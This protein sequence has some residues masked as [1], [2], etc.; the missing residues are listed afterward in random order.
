MGVGYHEFYALVLPSVKDG[1]GGVDD[2]AAGDSC[3]EQIGALDFK[4]KKK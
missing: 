4:G 2:A 3:Y 1:G